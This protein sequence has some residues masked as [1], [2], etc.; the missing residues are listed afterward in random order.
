MGGLDKLVFHEDWPVPS[1][2]PNQLLL[3]LH[4]CG[5]NNT[6]VDTRSGGYSKAVSEATTGG[7]Y[8]EVGKNDPTWGGA[9]INFPRI[10]GADV[11]GTVV[12]AGDAADAGLIGQRVM[13][14]C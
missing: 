4:A 3:K 13:A 6:D 7:A 12:A 9:P 5:P 11:V 8:Q 1:P 14:D 2:S 10:Q